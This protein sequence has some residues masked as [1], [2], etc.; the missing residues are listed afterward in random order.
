MLDGKEAPTFT[1]YEYNQAEVRAA[2]AFGKQE[3]YP[4][5]LEAVRAL[6]TGRT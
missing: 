5:Q 6:L 4:T 1:E 2:Q 3:L